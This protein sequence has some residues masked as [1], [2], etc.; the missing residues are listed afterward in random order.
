MVP[1]SPALS[2]TRRSSGG[3][4]PNDPRPRPLGRL[5]MMVKRSSS[6]VWSMLW[7]SYKIMEQISDFRQ[8]VLCR[9]NPGLRYWGLVR[10]LYNSRCHRR[11]HHHRHLS[12]R[13]SNHLERLCS[14]RLLAWSDVRAAICEHGALYKILLLAVSCPSSLYLSLRSCHDPRPFCSI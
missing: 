13:D 3:S 6:K 12:S 9:L 11:R 5:A 14:Y 1:M 8:E 2:Q 7:R 4:L 10:R